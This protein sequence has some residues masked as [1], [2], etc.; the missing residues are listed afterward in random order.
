MHTIQLC[1]TLHIVNLLLAVLTKEQKH[2]NLTPTND[3]VQ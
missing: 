1:Y 2:E 3:H